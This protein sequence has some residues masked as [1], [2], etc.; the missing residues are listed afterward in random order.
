[1]KSRNV[2][3]SARQR[4]RGNRAGERFK[5]RRPPCVSLS[6]GG[7]IALGQP[8]R[9]GAAIFAARCGDI[10]DRSI[11]PT[12]GDRDEPAATDGSS[13]AKPST[14]LEYCRLGCQVGWPAVV[15]ILALAY[16]ALWIIAGAGYAN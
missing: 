10:A 3:K 5:N 2:R 11:A 9:S 13:N 16:T 7:E 8:L 15:S 1:M 6:P 4:K 14:A 12:V